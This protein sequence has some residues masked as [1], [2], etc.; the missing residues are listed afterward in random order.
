MNGPNAVVSNDPY[1]EIAIQTVLH[2]YKNQ[3]QHNSSYEDEEL[4][5]EMAA[6]INSKACHFKKIAHIAM[7]QLED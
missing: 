2:Q 4:F 5:K 6:Q 7:K 1:L 3:L